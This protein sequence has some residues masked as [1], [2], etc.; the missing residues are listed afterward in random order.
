MKDK[1][2]SEKMQEQLEPIPEEEP[3]DL[4]DRKALK[5]HNMTVNV[6]SGAWIE[7]NFADPPTVPYDDDGY[8]PPDDGESLTP[9]LQDYKKST[10]PDVDSDPY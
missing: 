6:K 8:D 2:E 7:K 10:D 4:N 9:W 3:K 5:H 1:T